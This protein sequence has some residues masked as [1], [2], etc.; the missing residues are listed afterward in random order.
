MK[1]ALLVFADFVHN[2]W[3]RPSQ[4]RR[5]L[6]DRAVLDH[7]LRR[8]GRI[9][10]VDQRIVV[11]RP[12][13][14]D[15][16][17][18]AAR[19]FAEVGWQI[20]PHDNGQRPRQ[21]LLSS[22]RK[23]NMPS[24]R[25]GLTN[26]TWYDEFVEPALVL[27]ALQSLEADAAFCFEGHQAALDPQLCSQMV[28]Q[29][30]E[31][32]PPVKF[33]FTAAPPGL[34]GLL[35][36]RSALTELCSAN[37]PFGVLVTYRP[38][39]PM[40]DPLIHATCVQVPPQVART[41]RR[42]LADRPAGV[43]LLARLFA[44]TGADADAAALCDG[45]AEGGATTDGDLPAE[46]ELE[47]TTADPIPNSTILPRGARA[48]QADEGASRRL[49]LP[50]Q[51]LALRCREMTNLAGLARIAREFAQREDALLVL[52]GHGDPLQH[53]Q[54]GT[55]LSLIREAGVLGVAVE[56]TLLDTADSTLELLLTY[57]VDALLVR[58]D[59][60]SAETY[61]TIHGA[62]RFA[63][64][65][66]G[67]GYIE[68]RRRSL[69][70]PQ[71]LLAPVFTK[72]AANLHELDGFFDSWI[73]RCGSAVIRG[74]ND[75]CGALPVDGLLHA[76]PPT[77]GPCRRLDSRLMLLAD[78]SVSWC[79]QDHL[80]RHTLGNWYEQSLREIW[81]GEPLARLRCTHQRHE[82]STLPLCA[83]C[84]EWFRP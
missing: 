61:A 22:A 32:D 72:C 31:A 38:E 80:G 56:S 76:A 4:L 6:G 13:D 58:L 73:R 27:A 52:A 16:A 44:R 19:P 8:A 54:I 29:A 37:L 45:V 74:Y 50:G 41:K 67:I 7:T 1:I 46:I 51:R 65:L 79:G 39:Y 68:Q 84:K 55:I 12:R 21:P 24:W 75:Y 82:W 23:W 78:G 33:V 28:R 66:A 11:V 18:T 2:F 10:G 35:L 48:P 15:A 5:P 36:H 47:L 9:Q 59:A 83:A 69:A 53:P 3:G 81:Q 25:G 30:R 49:A 43:E 26:A 20:W 42:L 71:P 77:R 70:Q 63:D 60:T 64:A 14:A 40:T 34:A 57:R 62:D 17:A